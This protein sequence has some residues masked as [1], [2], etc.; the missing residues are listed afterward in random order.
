MTVAA[1]LKEAVSLQGN[2]GYAKVKTYLMIGK[3]ERVSK[4]NILPPSSSKHHDF[5]DIIW[6]KRLATSVHG[7]GLRF[8]A[9]ESDD[10]KFLFLISNI[11]HIYKSG[12]TVSTWPGSTSITRILVAINSLLNESVKVLTAAFVAQ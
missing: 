3:D 9:V 7:I 5:C 12:L 2:L 11:R 6:R 4:H 10:G 1:A 8:V